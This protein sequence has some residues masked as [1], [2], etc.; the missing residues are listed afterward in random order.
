M[1]PGWPYASVV[2]ILLVAIGLSVIA[3]ACLPPTPPPP[4]NGRLPDSML[5]TISPECRVVNEIAGALSAMLKDANRQGV[6]LAPETR[7]YSIVPPPRIESCYRS[8][9]MQVW[10]RDYYCYFGQCG[11]AAVPGTSVHGWGRA[12]DFQDQ[13]GEMTFDSPGYAWLTANAWRYG[14]SH[15]GWANQGSPNAEAWHWESP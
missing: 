7:S 4:E 15:P 5:T 6:A 8:Y 9:D 3:T 14:F 13:F 11:F 12:V 1:A 10:W 2:R